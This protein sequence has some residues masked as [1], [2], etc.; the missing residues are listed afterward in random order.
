MSE[1]NL[2]NILG[3]SGASGLLITVLGEFVRP[4]TGADGGTSEGVWTQTLI[5]VL[6]AV[7]VREKS[8]RQSVARLHERGWL[9]KQAIGR[10][11]RWT[12]TSWA[13]ELLTDGAERIY[14]FGQR[15]V[16]GGLGAP[17]WSGEWIVL[18]AS[19]PEAERRTRYRLTTR[20]RWIGL[21]TIGQGVWISPRVE[22]LGE[23]ERLLSEIGMTSSPLFVASLSERG[24]PQ[25]LATQAW[26][27]PVL[28]NE[29]RHFL[30]TSSLDTNTDDTS[31]PKATIATDPLVEL[32]TLVHHWRYFPSIDPDLPPELLPPDFP[33][34]PAAAVFSQRRAALLEPAWER[35]N[36]IEEA[37]RPRSK[38]S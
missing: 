11:T 7:G 10:Q 2:W 32:T 27:L 14:R 21:G 9:S 15:E 33:A 5:E 16:A 28:A 4:G 20:L 24:D 12:L 25:R 36:A 30:E 18:L 22:R 23:V 35:W 1:T 19:L 17:T 29:Y 6:D 38:A 13:D 8:A 34:A 31:C 3:P 26:D 37:Y